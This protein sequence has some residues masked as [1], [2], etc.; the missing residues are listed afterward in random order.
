MLSV[1]LGDFYL[2]CFFNNYQFLQLKVGCLDGILFIS[3]NNSMKGL[4]CP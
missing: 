1:Q 3:C 4:S 2:I